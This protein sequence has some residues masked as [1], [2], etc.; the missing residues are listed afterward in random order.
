MGYNL[1]MK[2][3]HLS[4]IPETLAHDNL[5]R[6]QFISPGDLKSNIQTVNYAELK[7]GESFTPHSHPDCEECFF[8]IEGEALATIAGEEIKIKKEDFIVVEVGEE[9]A[10]IN[11]EKEVFKYF[12]F[13]V[14]IS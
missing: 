8:I 14:L 13:R 12:A 1:V 5:K 10:F 11:K 6:K 2:L 9:H 7:E 3:T 4:E